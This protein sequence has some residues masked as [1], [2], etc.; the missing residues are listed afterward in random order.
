MNISVNS[1]SLSSS[2][3]IPTILTHFSL[4]HIYFVRAIIL[5]I[6]IRSVDPFL[7]SPRPTSGTQFPHPENE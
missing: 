2:L 6:G 7:S 1:V 5:G 3:K 4:L